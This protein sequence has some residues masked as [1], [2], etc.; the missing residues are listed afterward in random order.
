MT[1]VNKTF[2]DLATLNR[3]T[4]A[5]YFDSAGVL[6]TAPANTPRFNYNP[7]N[8]ASNGLL[9]EPS[10]T[11]LITYSEQLDNAA[12]SKL[13]CS[14]SAD[15]VASPNGI[16]SADKVVEDTSA[17]STHPVFRTPTLLSSTSYIYSFFVK[18]SGRNFIRLNMSTNVVTPLSGDVD[19]TTGAYTTTTPSR[20]SVLSCG[21]GWYRVAGQITTNPSVV[22]STNLF[23]YMSSALGQISYT[24]DGVSGI[25]LWGLQLEVGAGPTS[26]IPT[27]STAT[28]RGP[29]LL[30]VSSSSGW[31]GSNT[32]FNIDADVGIVSSINS[33]GITAS[34][35]GHIRSISY[36][37]NN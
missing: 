6:Q 31:L 33:G 8:L 24:G 36:F 13:R 35:N 20:M 4:T 19:L 32:S 37:P 23:I 12:W 29:D 34:G 11:N 16:L 27:T 26:Y 2:A 21:N 18:A 17:N 28:S 1:L 5:T 14:V 30:T 9:I 25:Y 3:S 10:T 15:S 7:S 22:G